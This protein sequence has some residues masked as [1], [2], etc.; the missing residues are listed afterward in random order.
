MTKIGG[1]LSVAGGYTKALEK[2]IEIGGNSLQIFASSPRQWLELSVPDSVTSE[3]VTLKK[4]LDVDPVYFHASYLIN[5]ADSGFI[6]NRSKKRILEELELAERMDI[7]GTIIHLG[8][9]KEE[10]KT[11]PV[12]EEKYRVLLQNISWVLEHSKATSY[13]IIEDAGNRKIGWSFDEIAQIISDIK[14]DRV[15]VCVDTCHMFAAGYDI[16]TKEK[17][18]SFFLDFEKKIGLDKLEVFQV[19]DS[20]DA[21]GSFRDRHENIGEG[22]IPESVFELLLTESVTKDKPFILEV[23]GIDKKGPNKEQVAVLK[24][25]LSR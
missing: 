9:Y 21:L 2:T 13:F 23:P 24:H 14:D 5:M 8:S 7:K 19:N 12:S 22:T 4:R 16:S 1:H 3:F 10:D 20:K 11:L 15:R 6:G 18:D 17:F 25:F